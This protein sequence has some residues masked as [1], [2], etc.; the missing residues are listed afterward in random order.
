MTPARGKQRP[1]R[2][3]SPADRYNKH[4]GTGKKII[5]SRVFVPEM[6]CPDEE[7]EIRSALSRIPGVE[8]LS[9]RLFSRQVEVRHRGDLEEILTALRSIG[10]E[11]HPIDESLR[12]AAI[13][14]AS[15][16]S[17]NTFFLS[18]ALLLAGAV[19]SVFLPGPGWPTRLFAA[20]VIAGGVRIAMGAAGSPAA[21]ET[22]DVALMAEDLRKIPAAVALGR[23]MV[24]II[25][26]NVA[27]SLAIKA[28]FLGLAVTGYVTLWMAVAA[29]MGTTLLVI[30][31]GL[32]LLRNRQAPV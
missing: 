16:A 1:A 25:R 8:E 15:R 23:R 7:K 14:E 21:I 29:D 22:A 17:L 5:N 6:D 26:Q 4:M 31:N 13:P 30:G 24:S 20:A 10:M 27:V 18:A 2:P 12:K 32:R 9:F 11:G 19:L 28:G 3:F